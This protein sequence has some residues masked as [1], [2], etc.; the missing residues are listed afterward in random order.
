[1][2]R[3]LPAFLV[4]LLLAACGG[5]PAASP[6]VAPPASAVVDATATVA[7]PGATATPRPTATPPPTAT[8]TPPPTATLPPPPLSAAPASISLLPAWLD[9]ALAEGQD[10]E[11]VQAALEAAGFLAEPGAWREVDLNGDGQAEWVVLAVQEEEN[12]AVNG[13]PGQLFVM[14]PATGR[15]LYA[16]E[17]DAWQVVFLLPPTEMTGDGL[18]DLAYY[19]ETCGAHTCYQNYAVLSYHG[20]RAEPE[21]LLVGS[22]DWLFESVDPEP[23]PVSMPYSDW[24]LEDRTGDGL[25]DLALQGGTIGSVG[26]GPQRS[27]YELYGWDGEQI[28]LLAREMEESSARYFRLVDAEERFVSG[29][30]A[31]ALP[32]YEQVIEDDTLEALE[33]FDTNEETEDD[34]RRYATFRLLVAALS[35]GENARAASRLQSAQAAYP[36][37]PLIE[38]AALLVEQV[39][40]G[41]P[42]PAACASAQAR[43]AE[44]P[45]VTGT[46]AYFGYANPDF[47]AETLC[48]GVR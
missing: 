32:L 5:A 40:A 11:R 41:E 7:A 35:A 22:P 48:R 13:T 3:R 8:A 30:A 46:V 38:A 6:T 34:I 42:L 44:T 4:L 24:T 19:S 1:M 47:T 12:G 16:S 14:E 31:A 18:P 2:A 37:H 23:L 20:G 21:N 43:A 15:R 45:E 36:G 28:S 29:D 25:D 9:A 10:G 26:A 17:Y 39:A 33:F 27:R